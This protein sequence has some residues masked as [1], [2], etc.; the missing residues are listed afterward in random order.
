MTSDELPLD[1]IQSVAFL[2]HAELHE[3]TYWKSIFIAI[4]EGPWPGHERRFL[5][6]CENPYGAVVLATSYVLRMGHFRG[7]EHFASVFFNEHS[8]LDTGLLIHKERTRTHID[9]GNY[10]TDWYIQVPRP[11]CQNEI[12]QCYRAAVSILILS[13]T[14]DAMTFG[15][16]ALENQHNVRKT[17]DAYTQAQISSN[18]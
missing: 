17:D 11:K 3:D 2:E 6:V 13:E 15:Q 16:F 5:E 10:V 18:D 12:E 9:L 4:L 14:I 8:Q 1:V 7:Y